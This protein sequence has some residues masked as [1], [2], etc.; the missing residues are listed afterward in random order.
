VTTIPVTARADLTDE[1]W[2]VLEPFLPRGKKL[3][4]PPTWSKRQLI[5]GIR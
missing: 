5:D 3:G 2:V 4:R 1:Q